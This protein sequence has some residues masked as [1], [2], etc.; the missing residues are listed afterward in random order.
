MQNRTFF[1]SLATPADLAAKFIPGEKEWAGLVSYAKKDTIQLNAIPVKDKLEILQ[2]I[3]TLMARQIWRTEGYF[4]VGNRNDIT[5][6]KA[7][8]HLK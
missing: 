1:N 3:Q 5:V 2:R 8:A 7:L 4:E 6:Q